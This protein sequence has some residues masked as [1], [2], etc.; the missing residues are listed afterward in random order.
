MLP[1]K[2]T[3]E[4]F[5]TLLAYMKTQVGW[6]PLEKIRKTLP[7]KATDN[8]KLEAMRTIGLIERDNTNIKVSDAGW[9]YI[10]ST[11]SADKAAV[12]RDQLGTVQLYVDTVHWMHYN[13]KPEPTRTD[14]ANYWHDKHEGQIQGAK[15]AALTDAAVFFLR[16]AAGAGL[17]T[18]VRAGNNR[19]DTYLKGDASAISAFTLG[20]TTAAP[21]VEST[22]GDDVEQPPTPPVALADPPPVGV[23]ATPPVSPPAANLQTSPNIH[24]N[25]EIHIAADATP[26][27]VR[28]IFRNMRKYVLNTPKIE[29]DDGVR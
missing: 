5:D 13:G 17:G 10:R 11:E 4:D 28:E 24:V 7:T 8:R 15:G 3:L 23:G 25:L 19:P 9:K 29:D 2:T 22:S 12:L 16:L 27:T 20:P 1:L 14:V 18:F 26:D 6:V 21:E